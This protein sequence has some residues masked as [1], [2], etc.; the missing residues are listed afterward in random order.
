LVA[1]M[2]REKRR[3]N[4]YDFC[5]VIGCAMAFSSLRLITWLIR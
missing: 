2:T 5:L 1:A 4:F 3:E